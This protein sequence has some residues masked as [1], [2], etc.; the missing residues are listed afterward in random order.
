MGDMALSVG[1]RETSGLET[2]YIH[3]KVI[4]D[5]RAAGVTNPCS[6]LTS[7]PLRDLEEV[8]ALAVR[9]RNFGYLGVNLIHPSHVPIANEVFG[10]SESDIDY[11][12]GLV[13]AVEEGERRGTSA[14][15]YDGRMVD[16]AHANFAREMLKRAA[17]YGS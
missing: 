11:W 12:T 8:R 5:A 17:E 7:A 15:V 4:V 9:L 1:Y 10:P 6:G 14:V 3:S 13:A 16:I 2:A